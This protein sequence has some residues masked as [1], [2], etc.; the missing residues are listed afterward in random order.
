MTQKLTAVALKMLQNTTLE[1]G[2]LLCWVA[3]HYNIWHPRQASKHAC[4]Y[5]SN[6]ACPPLRHVVDLEWL[7]SRCAHPPHCCCAAE[8]EL[9]H[10]QIL[11]HQEHSKQSAMHLPSLHPS[12]SCICSNRT[13]FR[14]NK[15]DF[16]LHCLGSYIQISRITPIATVLTA[17]CCSQTS[18]PLAEMAGDSKE[19]STQYFGEHLYIRLCRSSRAACQQLLVPY[20]RVT[21]LLQ[22]PLPMQ[23]GNG[24]MLHSPAGVACLGT[25]NPL[26]LL[27]KQRSPT[28]ACSLSS[29]PA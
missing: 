7:L 12:I 1:S 26:H 14:G 9:K 23:P 10:T 24:S 19:G 15:Q 11:Q 8:I 2:W 27:S 3:T 6:R 28:I 4:S 18:L 21:D 5:T 25:T 22:H 13:I 20:A 29:K 17:Y 16:W